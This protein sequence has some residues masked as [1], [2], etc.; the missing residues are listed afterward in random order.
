MTA[1]IDLRRYLEIVEF[2]QHRQRQAHDEGGNDRP[3]FWLDATN[4]WV[5]ERLGYTLDDPELDY[6][7]AGVNVL[8]GNFV[9]AG[10]W[11][12]EPS[13]PDLDEQVWLF[14]RAWVDHY[15]PLYPTSPTFSP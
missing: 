13:R 10:Y 11:I 7:I 12:D 6:F 14:Y 9:K 8:A 4:D 5:R 15:G 3:P 1:L 2:L